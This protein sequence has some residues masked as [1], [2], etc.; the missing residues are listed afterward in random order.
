MRNFLVKLFLVWVAAGSML[1]NPIMAQPQKG[2]ATL[3]INTGTHLSQVAESVCS[4]DGKYIITVSTDKTICIWDAAL[5]QLQEQIRPP[6]SVFNQGKIYAVAIS[7]DNKWLAIGGFLAIGTETDGELAGQIRIYDFNT[8][9]QVLRFRAHTNVVTALRFS[10]DGKY[11]LS[12]A[13]DSTVICWRQVGNARQPA[14]QRVRKIV[15]DDWYQEDIQAAGSYAYLT[16]N[17]RLVKYSVPGLNRIRTSSPYSGSILY[18]AIHAGSNLVA[19]VSNRNELIILDTLLQEKQ[20]INLPGATHRVTVS[21]DGQSL[22]TEGENSHLL[23]FRKINGLFTQTASTRFEGGATILGTGFLGNFRFYAAGGPRNLLQFYSIRDSA[24]G[25]VVSSDTVLGNT[26]RTFNQIAVHKN[27]IALRDYTS[28]HSS[29]DYLFYPEAGR[30]TRFHAADS[31]PLSPNI[32]EK[33]GIRVTVNDN[34]TE[35]QIWS[36]SRKSG[37][38]LRDG[39]SGYGHNCVTITAK[40]WIVSGGSAGFLEIY[41]TLGH[42]IAALVGHEGDV[43]AISESPEGDF[44]YS[45]SYD[46]TTRVWDLREIRAERKFR[47]VSAM[48][49]SWVLYFKQNYPRINPSAPGGMEKMYRAMIE[50]GDRLNAAYLI[51]PQQLEPR[52]NF[53]IARNDEWVIW[54]NKGYFKASSGGAAYVGWYIYKGEDENA[55]FYT[56][57]KFYDTYYRPDIINE[58]TRPSGNAVILQKEVWNTSSGL[59]LAEQVS[60]MPVLRLRSPAG[61]TTVSQKNI[62]LIFDTEHPEYIS[63]FLLFHNGKRVAVNKD[64]LRGG[65]TSDRSIQVEL[66]AGENVFSASLLNRNKVETTPLQFRI[67]YTGTQATSSLYIFAVGIDKY[68]NSRYNLNYA[69]ADANGISQLLQQSAGRIFKSVTID[70]LFD[71]QA[72][73]ANIAERIQSLKSK[74]RPEDVFLFY[75]AGHGVMGEPTDSSKADFY[76]VLHQ[77]VQMVGN[78]EMLR[79]FGLPARKLKELLLEIPAQK[80]LVILDA[81]NS[82]GAMNVFTRG[83]G[84]EAAISQL[85]RSTGFTVLA[86]TNQEQYAAEL[87]ELKHGIFTYAILNGLRGEADLMK[88]GKITVKEIELYLNDI[89]PV[90]SE[91]YKGVQQFPQSYSRGM[92]FPITLRPPE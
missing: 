78:E 64:A 71:E 50:N 34:A 54:N 79:K 37:S 46:Q 44:L 61:G 25:L 82:G 3:Q 92:D 23:L 52:Y 47:S 18:S 21:P 10:A 45:T 5:Q 17:D 53:F 91:K 41:D 6:K 86:S 29:F 63:D 13:N 38:V 28:D 57:D 48:D 19:M 8:R 65:N 40:N 30:L 69:R 62:R 33:D 85:A 72:N 42:P 76:L 81:C 87:S 55:E 35:L 9:K 39:G 4:P 83:G 51:L 12:G 56:A 32:H 74:I 90:L 60:N 88:D 36:G 49:S 26:G 58:L 7:P 24:G 66:V 75:Y 16:E 22:L 43:S 70:S 31:F 15:K 1:V 14:F 27:R 68:R 84:E 11:L 59:S 20:K 67:Q 2:D 89:I 73:L 77:V 80:Q